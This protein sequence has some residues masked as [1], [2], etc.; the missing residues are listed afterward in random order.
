MNRQQSLRKPPYT[1]RGVTEQGFLADFAGKEGAFSVPL[2][3]SA[4]L[5]W[6]TVTSQRDEDG[7]DWYDLFRLQPG[8]SEDWRNK[9]YIG[10]KK[11]G[12]RWG[13]SEKQGYIF[14]STGETV[15]HIFNSVVPAA[16]NVS[17]VDFQVTVELTNP[18]ETL[19]ENYY[20]HM[21]KCKKRKYTLIT[22]NNKG[23]TLYVGSR[24]SSS[25]GRVYDK[26]VESKQ[27][28]AGKIWRYE[29]E[30]KQPRSHKVARKLLELINPW[31]KTEDIKR[32]DLTL[33]VLPTV[34]DW[35]DDRGVLP[36]FDRD[37]SN[38][39]V[40]EIGR[41]V[42]TDEKKLEWLTTQVRPTIQYFLN[43]GLEERLEE[44]LGCSV[45]KIA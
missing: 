13:Y 35:F 14:M 27:A 8:L 15:P 11:T 29:I 34:Y 6:L 42:T 5:D 38:E 19:A 9:W 25:F 30:L 1:N 37:G 26:G 2:A 20:A 23:K 45:S 12:F 39:L 10:R 41:K 33:A 40:V 17:R 36:I 21:C 32:M 7:Y 43:K 3:V 24:Q 16:K 28:V 4:G 22:N 18:I 31:D 44:A